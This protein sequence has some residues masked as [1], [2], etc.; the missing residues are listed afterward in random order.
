MGRRRNKKKQ[1][2]PKQH[3][4]VKPSSDWNFVP[5]A[6]PGCHIARHDDASE[7]SSWVLEWE[8]VNPADYTG[9]E[10]PDIAVD[11]T[12]AEKW[13]LSLCNI[14][15][16]DYVVAYI[17]VF[18]TLLRNGRGQVLQQGSTTDNQGE[19]KPVTTLIV[20]CP[21]TTFAHLCFIDSL[22]SPTGSDRQSSHDEPPFSLQD[23]RIE[24]DVQVWHQHPNPSDTHTQTI[25]FP[26]DTTTTGST[27]TST[28]ST[29]SFLCTQ[30]E[31]GFL[32]HFFSGNFHSVDFQCPMGTP[33]LAVANGVVV[34]TRVDHTLTGVAVQNLFC[35]NSILL[36]LDESSDEHL[37]NNKSND[38]QHATG[39][40]LFVEYVHIQSAT[41][42]AGDRVEAGQVVGT[43]GSVGFSPEP[44]LHLSAYRSAAP[45]APTVRV[46]FRGAN[47]DSETVFLPR[48]GQWYDAN[49][50]VCVNRNQI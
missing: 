22:P 49:G 26:F 27:S 43:S 47:N 46:L 28:S 17:S 1:Q 30:G 34:E 39:G 36:R 24:S 16:N 31:G 35:W 21:P 37:V 6:G 33:L 3:R 2:Q 40:P 41:V 19:T 29:T 7:S 18:E 42:Q 4:D 45:T 11:T 13:T 48:A 14:R 20:L 32:T 25:R 5:K 8:Q 44:H 9:E 23:L 38:Y 50:P 10:I 12:T 15:A